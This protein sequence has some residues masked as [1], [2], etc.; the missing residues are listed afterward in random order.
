MN[1]WYTPYNGWYN[2]AQTYIW[3]TEN[4]GSNW[5]KTG[6]YMSPYAASTEQGGGY[7]TSMPLNIA[8]LSNDK[9]KVTVNRS[10]GGVAYMTINGSSTEPETSITFVKI[11]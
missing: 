10:T 7:L 11:G 9:V 6:A 5:Y 2:Q 4:D 3:G 8:D 1:I